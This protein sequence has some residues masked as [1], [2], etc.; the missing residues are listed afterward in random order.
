MDKRLLQQGNFLVVGLETR[1]DDLGDHRIRLALLAVLVRHHV[2]F[3]ADQRRI[4][5][6]GVERLGVGCGNMHRDLASEGCQLILLAGGFQRDDHA[7]LAKAVDHGAMDVASDNAIA[8]RK[9]GRAAQRHVFADGRNR[10]RDG[11]IDVE[12]ADL[13]SLD[14]LDIGAGLERNLADHL[15][16][17]LE[18]LVARDEVGLGIDFDENA[19]LA[20]GDGGDQTFS[21]NAAGLLRGLGEAL[22]AQPVNRRVDVACGFSEGLLAIHHARAGFLAQI[23]DHCRCDCCHCRMSFACAGRAA[24]RLLASRIR[25]AGF[26]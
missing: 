14:L 5:T 9:F 8:D 23:L 22:L 18:L 13:G 24:Q 3:A 17:A 7:H 12:F 26:F 10:V 2:L 21:R 16:Q 25:R 15:D 11:A 6:R 1:F 19:L 4:E 20:V